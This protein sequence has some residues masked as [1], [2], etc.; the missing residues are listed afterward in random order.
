MAEPTPQPDLTGANRDAEPPRK[1]PRLRLWPGV[2]ILLGYLAVSFGFWQLASTNVQSF[3]ALALVPLA[4]TLLLSLWWL[5][6]SRIPVKDRLLGLL[7]AVGA[8]AG[9]VFSQHANGSMLLA[10]ALP[11]LM[12]GVVVLLALTFRLRW[13]VRRWVLVV[14]VL[15]CGATFMALRADTIGGNLAPIVSWRWQATEAE[16]SSAFARTDARGTAALPAEAGPEDWPAFLGAARD[17]HLPG[18]K[19]STDWTTPPRELWR[20]KVGPGWSS[21][22]AVGDYVFTQEQRGGDEVCLC[23][24]AASGDEVWLNH[25]EARYEDTMG[26]G[27]RATP[28][29]DRGK[30]YVQGATG[31]LQCLDAATGNTVWKRDLS[32]DA[33]TG[34]PGYGFSSSPLVLGDQVIEFSCGGE[35]KN[36]VAYDRLSGEL[37]WRA[38]HG[39]ST[40]SSPQ[41]VTLGNVPQLLL[42]SNYGLQAFVPET[43]AALWDHEWRVGTNPRCVQPLVVGADKVLLGTTGTTG[44]RLLQVQGDNNAWTVKELWTTKRFRPYFNNFVLHKG[45]CY[46]FDGDRI[47]CLDLDTGERRWEGKRFGGQLLL[48]PDM[49]A[50]LVLSEKG[51]VVLLRAIPDQYSELARFQALHGKTWNHP[52]IAH[53]K[54]FVRNAE[55]A[56]CFTL[57]G[58]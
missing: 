40:Y 22:T 58:F 16:R 3:I 42:V 19:L 55:E 8:M 50:L 30:L 2:L 47:V 53:G 56:A 6:A 41:V 39:A 36:V 45:L 17:G 32:K 15:L 31:I 11:A 28:S 46:G 24:A 10:Y 52:V 27:P 1:E 12:T 20:R 38:G 57:P 9:V 34:V 14:F 37:R 49:D 33:E 51:E 18:V 44:S 23:Y 7:L 43:G 26:L 48:L 13:A 54:L 4:A 5:F 25:V 29:F 35:G 21:F